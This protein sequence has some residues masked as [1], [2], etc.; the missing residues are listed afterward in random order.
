MTVDPTRTQI[1]S[2][3]R[4]LPA[5]RDLLNTD[6]STVQDETVVKCL[7]FLRGTDGTL[8]ENLNEFGVAHLLRDKHIEYLYDSVELYPENFVGIDSSRPWMVYWALAGLSLLG[9]DVTKFRER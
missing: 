4:E 6:T 8:R 9:E 5:I 1:P 7:P 2:L 3:F